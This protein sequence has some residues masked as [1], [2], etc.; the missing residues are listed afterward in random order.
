MSKR[1]QILSEILGGAWA[2]DSSYVQ[3]YLPTVLS[4]IN[5][6]P[7]ELSEVKESINAR[8]FSA[9]SIQ[10]SLQT[11]TPKSVLVLGISG[12]MTKEDQFC[13]PVGMDTLGSYIKQAN[14]NPNIVGIVLKTNTPGGSVSGLETFGKTIS[15]SSKPVVMFADGMLASAGY[16]FGSACREIIAAGETTQIGSIGV[17][18]TLMDMRKALEDKGIKLHEIYSTLSSQ[19]NKPYQMALDGKPEML[20]NEVLNPLATFFQNTVKANRGEKV[21]KTSKDILEGKVVFA[22]E[23]LSEG[24]IDSIGN[25]EHAIN[26]VHELA[27]EQ[28]LNNNANQSNMKFNFKSAQKAAANFFGITLKDGAETTEGEITSEKMDELNAKLETVNALTASEA[29]LTT[30]LATANSSVEKLTADLATANTSLK[31]SQDEFEAFKKSN[32]GSTDAL[33][34][35]GTDSPKVIDESIMTDADRELAEYKKSI[36]S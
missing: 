3:G 6:T 20:Q 7:I 5:G 28:T 18:S 33:K 34:K 11:T 15:E 30:D 9:S 1:I 10:D 16:W 25:L 26:R 32:P 23:A 2:I 4:L 12:A 19:K 17:M 35:E 24:L 8:N 13:G 21:S 27:S 36:N 29:K 31:A 14:A 22:T